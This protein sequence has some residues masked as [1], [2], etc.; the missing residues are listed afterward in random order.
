MGRSAEM[1]QEQQEQEQEAGNEQ[2]FELSEMLFQMGVYMQEVQRAEM[3]SDM[4]EHKRTGY[5]E[6]MAEQADMQRK[7]RREGGA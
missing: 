4:P 2:Q 5:A 1:W 3:E 6:R 7:A